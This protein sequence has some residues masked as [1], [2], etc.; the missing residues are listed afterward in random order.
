MIIFMPL[1]MLL[2]ILIRF[3]SIRSSPPSPNTSRCI[4]LLL[5]ILISSSPIPS[6]C[7]LLLPFLWL[8]NFYN[9][10]FLWNS[11]PIRVNFGYNVSLFKFTWTSTIYPFNLT[12]IF[13]NT[14]NASFWICFP[15]EKN[16]FKFLINMINKHTKF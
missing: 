8:M 9:Y 14:K 13:N 7:T 3:F 12:F 1:I 5:R 15:S 4:S 2:R 11:R 6:P 16:L 10:W